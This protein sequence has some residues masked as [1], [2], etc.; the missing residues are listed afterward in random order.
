M[1]TRAI[2]HIG[3]YTAATSQLEI[4]S[5]RME[6]APPG[7]VTVE[8]LRNTDA[9]AVC[10]V[11]AQESAV[12]AHRMVHETRTNWPSI[13]RCR[14][15]ER[16]ATDERDVADRPTRFL[17]SPMPTVEE[18]EHVRSMVGHCAKTRGQCETPIS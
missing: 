1:E 12:R 4:R 16:D 14:T 2:V 9:N 7:P 17:R 13:Q 18:A 6:T 8:M 15:T 3:P 11:R 10:R 5:G